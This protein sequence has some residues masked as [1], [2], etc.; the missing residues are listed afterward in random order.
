MKTGTFTTL[1]GSTYKGEFKNGKLHGQGTRIF[2]WGE[3]Y[4][5]EWKNGKRHGKG[6]WTIEN[7]SLDGDPIPS[8]P[9]KPYL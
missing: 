3:K 4:E 5:G 6:V 2:V 7:T 8:K 1:G 9:L